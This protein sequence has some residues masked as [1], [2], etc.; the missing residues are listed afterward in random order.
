MLN[1]SIEHDTKTA[2]ESGAVNSARYRV[3]EGMRRWS[4]VDIAIVA[5]TTVTGILILVRHSLIPKAN[6]LLLFHALVLLV[7]ATLPPRGARWEN[8]P[9]LSWRK[10]LRDIA[11]FLRY[12]YP[13][14]LVIYF[15]EEVAHTVNV[16]APATPYWFEQYLYAADR[17]LFGEL[18]ALLLA[19]W[20]GLVQDE[21]IHFFYF[22]YYLIV[23][24]GAVIAWFG[25]NG[26]GKSQPGP[27][28]E[29]AMTTTVLA[30]FFSFV[31]YPLLPAR[32]PWE[33]PEVMAGLAPFEGVVFTPLMEWIIGKGAVS[34]GCF[35]SS[36]VSG[37]WG[38]VFGLA[39]FHRR[40]A[41]ILGLIA[42]GMSFA[43][44]YTRYHHAV[45]IPAGFLMAAVAA[46]VAYRITPG[47][48]GQ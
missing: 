31:W 18:P 1:P 47:K 16:I 5:Y 37:A 41:L 23:V 35:P 17:W 42:A 29:T 27:G 24:G 9:L 10:T 26:T 32:G 19:G 8:V 46:L 39:R 44:I 11:R 3:T 38:M 33:N 21:L 48:G 43:C 12:T 45:D 40:P 25:V 22:S 34:G 2:L 15:F 36:H 14:A 6:S 13:L 7:V 20:T 28:I 4:A 30:Y